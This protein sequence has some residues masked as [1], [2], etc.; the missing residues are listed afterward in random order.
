MTENYSS[1]VTLLCIKIKTN[2]QVTPEAI[3]EVV[4]D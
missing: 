3:Q 2:L 4:F 1:E